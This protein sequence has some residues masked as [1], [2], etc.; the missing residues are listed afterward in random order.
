MKQ[1]KV[2]VVKGAGDLATGVALRLWRTGFA[3]IMTELAKPLAVR[4]TVAFAEAIFTGE[5]TVEGI[6]AKRCDMADVGA[7]LNQRIIPVL[8]DPAAQV[9]ALFQPDVLVD[10]IMAKVNTGTTLHDAPLVLALGPGFTAGIDC[11]AVVETNRGH[12]LGRALWQGSAE[13]DTGEPGRLPGV[14]SKGSRV[15]RAPDAGR[16]EAH[17]PIGAFVA[18]GAQVATLHTAQDEQIPVLAGVDGVLRGLIHPSVDV[19]AGT[20]IGDID[21]R[22]AP[23][24]CYTVSDKSLA[25][26]GGVLEA[27]LT[28]YQEKWLGIV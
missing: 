3:V 19:T 20:K 1:R 8:V 2:V 4:R 16:I 25:I 23:D 5:Q 14:E 21:P 10:A 7:L 24:H 18:S 26:A 22:A 13:P 9:L 17:V 27:I 12:Y 15:L 6:Q 28:V 11:H